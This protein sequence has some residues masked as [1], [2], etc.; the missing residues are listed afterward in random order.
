MQ[1]FYS[2]MS[3]KEGVLQ[4]KKKFALLDYLE[5]YLKQKKNL[6]ENVKTKMDRLISE[7]NFGLA[8]IIF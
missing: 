6:I 4:D 5:F 7:A 8:Q 2:W 1:I 3:L